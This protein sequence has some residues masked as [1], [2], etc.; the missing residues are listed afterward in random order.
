MNVGPICGERLP[1]KILEHYLH[2]N[3]CVLPQIFFNGHHLKFC[4]PD[5]CDRCNS[6]SNGSGLLPSPQPVYAT[7]KIVKWQSYQINNFE[8][9]K[10]LKTF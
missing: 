7:A 5:S 1:Q 8:V 6:C 2:L 10:K 4:S 3:Q 9:R